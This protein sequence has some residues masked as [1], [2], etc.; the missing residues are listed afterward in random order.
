VRCG[1]DVDMRYRCLPGGR[2]RSFD[3]DAL[4]ETQTPGGRFHMKDAAP[5]L[6]MVISYWAYVAFLPAMIIAFVFHGLIRRKD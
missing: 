1:V 4:A 6:T 3:A 5:T 2:N